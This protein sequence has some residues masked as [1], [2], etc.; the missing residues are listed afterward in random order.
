MCDRDETIERPQS[1]NIAE[2]ET[3]PPSESAAELVRVL[4]E[5]MAVLQA[6]EA[7][8]RARVLAE[9]PAL[10][11]QLEPCLAGI[12]FIHRA[13][14]P[15]GRDT[16]PT[17]LGEFRILREVGRGGMGVVYEAEQTSLRRR[18][19]LKVLRFGVVADEEAIRRFRVEAETVARLHH[20]NIVPIFAVGTEHDVSYYAMQFI[21]GQSLADV[22]DESVR[23]GRPIP[24]DDVARWGLQAA[25]ALA[26]A[27]LRRV[28]HRDIKPSN[29][30]ID[31]EGV[32]WLT[33]FG[34][35]KREDEVTLTLSGVLM[36]TPRYMSP[37]QAEAMKRPVDHRTDLYSLGASL[38]ELATG[39][40]VFDSASPHDVIMKVLTTDP[41]APRSVRAGIPKDLETIL[42]TCLAKEPGHRYATATAL[43]ED[44]RA[45]LAGRSIKARRTP[46]WEKTARWVKKQKKSVAI[47]TIAAITS[48]VLAGACLAFWLRHQEAKLGR[49]S[50]STRGETLTVE[51]LDAKRDVR[52]V[53]P[54][55]VPTRSPVA[56]P[57]G[58]YRVRLSAPRKLSETYQL[59]LERWL[60][61]NYEL[62]LA[63]RDFEKANREQATQETW[64]AFPYH[65][66][67][68]TD[69]DL[70]EI[71][72]QSVS[73][74]AYGR[75]PVWAFK[76]SEKSQLPPGANLN[77]W[78]NL[79]VGS[80]NLPFRDLPPGIVQSMPDLDRD[81]AGDIIVASRKQP[82]VFALSGKSGMVLWHWKAPSEGPAGRDTWSRCTGE[83]LVFQ[84]PNGPVIVTTV[85]SGRV[86]SAGIDVRRV[87]AIDG[88]NGRAIWQHIAA[89][90]EWRTIP[91]HRLGIDGKDV[92]GLESG[93]EWIGL[94]PLSGRP[95]APALD[96]DRLVARPTENS[97][98]YL[99][100]EPRV[101]DLDGDGSEDLLVL[102]GAGNL[103]HSELIAVSVRDRRL[104][105]TAAVDADF[106]WR[107]DG[108]EPDATW[109]RL[110]DLDADGRVEV[111]VP[112]RAGVG[113]KNLRRTS[114]GVRAL[115]GRDG[116]E[117]WSHRLLTDRDTTPAR[118]FVAGP[119][120]D[121]DGFRDVFV[122]SFRR[123]DSPHRGNIN[124]GAL[125]VDALSGRDGRSLWWW[126]QRVES[127]E[128]L[129]RP[130]RFWERG[131]D[132][133]PKLVVD[134]GSN[135]V[136]HRDISTVF[137]LAASTGRLL[138]QAAD[139]RPTGSADI[140]GDGIPELW[141]TSTYAATPDA[142]RPVVVSGLSPEVWKRMGQWEVGRDYNRDGV[143]D[144]VGPASTRHNEVAAISGRDG[145][146]IWA[147]KPD[148]S[149]VTNWGDGGGSLYHVTPLPEK[150][151]D[152]DGDG[153]PEIALTR[154]RR[155]DAQ[156]NG[157]LT[158]GLGVC[159]GRTGTML[160]D[161]PAVPVDNGN[162][163]WCAPCN[164]MALDV[165]GRGRADIVALLYRQGSRFDQSGLITFT[166]FHLARFSGESGRLLAVSKIA[167]KS[168]GVGQY[169]NIAFEDFASTVVDADGHPE[170]VYQL[171]YRSSSGELTSEF[172]VASPI[173]GRVVWSHHGA[174]A[175]G[176]IHRSDDIWSRFAAADLDGDSRAEVVLIDVVNGRPRVERWDLASPSAP[177]WIW[178]GDDSDSG[179]LLEVSAIPRVVNVDGAG[180]KVIAVVADQA[181]A[182]RR[183]VILNPSGRVVRA[184]P[185]DSKHLG[186]GIW[187]ADL[188]GDG[189][190]EILFED[191][192]KLRA[193]GGDLSGEV[194][195]SPLVANINEI[196]H[197]AGR[198][199]VLALASGVALDSATGRPIYRAERL[200]N[201][202]LIDAPESARPMAVE[203]LPTR[204]TASMTS[205]ADATDAMTGE[206]IPG[207]P[208]PDDPRIVRG[209]PWVVG[210]P[211]GLSE[212]DR[213]HLPLIAFLT[214]A[215]GVYSLAVVVAPVLLLSKVIAR[216]GKLRH[217]LLI[218]VMVAAACICYSLFRSHVLANL[219]PVPAAVSTVMLAV[220]GLPILAVVVEIGR[221]LW[222]KG[223]RSVPRS[224]LLWGAGCVVAACF[225]IYL[226]HRD[227][228]DPAEHYGWEGWWTIW[229]PGFYVA[230][231]LLIAGKVVSW[232]IWRLR[233]LVRARS[234]SA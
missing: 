14:S 210:S 61:Q 66:D 7:P 189:K 74:M 127:E 91:A 118:Q 68:R 46:V 64:R 49:L 73:R 104:L 153:V 120:V 117:R 130:L 77:E 112:Y 157:M 44:L 5:Y 170:I 190:D 233:G 53:E 152:L 28:I 193:V 195:S 202:R 231:C 25:E 30:L 226:H 232:P 131:P 12:D 67:G 110:V 175:L 165:E 96:F 76:P 43:A 27:H 225:L 37:E 158:I 63:R 89:R 111:L 86:G 166:D 206:P 123:D 216:K 154:E 227:W 136:A 156:G 200:V 199:K 144:L 221:A 171:P 103:N 198:G 204:T 160:W 148:L 223:W 80:I 75:K 161:G 215:A 34:L 36:G 187:A 1:L 217:L 224:L 234:A 94:D 2:A 183:V 108:L 128:S 196:R 24:C 140:D 163:H 29:L 6:G 124:P 39:R 142:I 100:C 82:V 169:D 141:G 184:R 132:G 176:A 149:G 35:A 146:V 125:F 178:Q 8:D 229:L 13:G 51:I 22:L 92:V 4:D 10:A 78:S 41:V 114:V 181:K 17:M 60:D 71:D 69:L 81:G 138:H 205:P 168:E 97:E 65:V 121:G 179:A 212:R 167:V 122:A 134:I 133:F 19:A 87:E 95:I 174:L 98:S 83:P 191:Q 173:D 31:A 145:S 33:D 93:P 50:L 220:V 197:A 26:H 106:T 137:V 79:L 143:P 109:P 105:W 21:E 72:Q 70:I 54:F 15:T 126:S 20:T 3:I 182:G 23:T 11:A 162:I 45:F 90:H 115:D 55:T 164:V 9:H 99:L 177:R 40:P 222:R 88:C 150:I 207:H 84:G 155:N 211:G 208:D 147:T 151:G 32:V 192:S 52:V 59:R 180:K 139:F 203:T 47:G 56:L 214:F 188:D 186:H 42:L 38:Y 57:E 58:D 62:D 228:M 18:V 102:R 172:V 48:V 185:I 194:W 119:D 107:D 113:P 85:E 218:P 116:R 159:S 230:G 101:A 129:S 213:P 219:P 209:L 135:F 16:A 201:F